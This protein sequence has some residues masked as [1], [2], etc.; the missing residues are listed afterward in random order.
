MPK[1]TLPA[2]ATAAAA[3]PVAETAAETA[4]DDATL[5]W[6]TTEFAAATLGDPRRT[7]RL[8]DLAETL[9]RTPSASLP[10]AC[11]DTAQLEEIGAACAE[12]KRYEFLLTLAPLRL[13][14]GTGGPI[15]PIA[16]F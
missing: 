11:R 4:A 14:R 13:E 7:A 16:L 3:T 15:N 12:P 2:S 8:R 5:T 6:A 1:A 9:A 10:M